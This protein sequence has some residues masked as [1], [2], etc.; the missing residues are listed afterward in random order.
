MKK[1]NVVFRYS[2][3]IEAKN[4]EEAEE[5]ALRAFQDECPTLEEMAVDVEE[6]I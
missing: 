3:T 2:Y 1:Y 6:L 5:L 4:E